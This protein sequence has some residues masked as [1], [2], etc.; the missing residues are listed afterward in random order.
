MVYGYIFTVTNMQVI[1]TNIGYRTGQSRKIRRNMLVRT[2]VWEPS[3]GKNQTNS[4]MSRRLVATAMKLNIL[5]GYVAKG[6]A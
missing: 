4:K 6:K 2:G 5:W 1:I 3:R